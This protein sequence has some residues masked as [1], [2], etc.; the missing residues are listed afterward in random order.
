[1]TNWKS[2]LILVLSSLLFILA[3]S[4]ERASYRPIRQSDFIRAHL[5]RMQNIQERESFALSR[6]FIL[7]DKRSLTKDLKQKFSTLHINHLF[8]PSGIHFSSFFILFLPLIKRLRKKELKKTAL[9]IELILCLLPFGLNQLY[10][11]KRISILRISN[12]IFKKLNLK[13]NIFTIFLLSFF[14]DFIFGTYKQSPMSY[15]F[16]FLF[17]GSLLATPKLSSIALSFFSANLFITLFFPSTVS[18]IGFFL[19]FI[20]TSLFSITFPFLFLL[21]WVSSLIS[22]D[23]TYLFLKLYQFLVN[24]FYKFSILGPS[25]EIDLIGY[26]FLLIFTIIRRK[27][28]LIFAIILSSNRVYNI[29]ME[30]VSKSNLHREVR[31]DNWKVKGQKEVGL[32]KVMSCRRVI[33]SKGH[34]ITCRKIKSKKG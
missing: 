22:L 28:F 27:R 33:L 25:V 20:F 7:G 8:T 18:L 19:G 9:A 13:M 17:L 2:P 1:M 15:A 29:P 14:F 11:L 3:L 10:S 31:I 6:A 21:Y 4:K 5:V 23:L 16:S 26:S 32:N 30:R 12:L 34:R 24:S